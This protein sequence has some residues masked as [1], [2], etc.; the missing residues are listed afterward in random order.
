MENSRNKQVISFKLC[1]VLSGMVNSNSHSPSSCV[2]PL[3]N[4]FM[5]YMLPTRQPLS[6]LPGNLVNWYSVASVWYVIVWLT[7]SRSLSPVSL[8]P[9][10]WA[11]R[12]L[13][14]WEGWVQYSRIL[15]L[16]AH[17]CVRVFETSIAWREGWEDGSVVLI[18]RYYCLKK[19]GR[20][21]FLIPTLEKQRQLDPWGI[22]HQLDLPIWWVQA[23]DLVEKVCV[24]GWHRTVP[25]IVLWPQICKHTDVHI[26][27]TTDHIYNSI[28][29]IFYNYS[30][31]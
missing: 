17:T 3:P 28:F 1:A 16:C 6:R 18:S 2:I 12:L 8:C 11:L 31:F 5:F 23:T 15:R 7:T 13:S 4:V 21:V 22:S 20:M 25:Q 30:Y 26:H 10:I 14:T 19:L 9:I 29:I 24:G 27:P